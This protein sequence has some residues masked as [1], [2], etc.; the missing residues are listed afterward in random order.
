MSS[1]IH[2][3][4]PYPRALL[5]HHGHVYSLPRSTTAPSRN[6]GQL[7]PLRI[8][9][10]QYVWLRSQIAWSLLL[11]ASL[12]ELDEVMDININMPV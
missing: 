7:F 10:N 3:V 6:F 2:S 12:I 9:R 4:P 8:Y 5:L 11:L 1:F